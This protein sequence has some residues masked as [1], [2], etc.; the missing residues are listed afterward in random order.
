MSQVFDTAGLIASIDR[1]S[2][3]LKANAAELVRQAAAGL[4]AD[5][6]AKMPRGT[7]PHRPGQ[8]PR[9]LADRVTAIEASDLIHIVYSNAPHLHLVE[10][11][12][13]ARANVTRNGK[14]L[15]TPAYRG[16]MPR[17]G[18]IF[19]PLAESHRARMLRMAE[20]LIGLDVEL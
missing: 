5:H 9:H 3:R 1:A 11:G 17:M 13:R 16:E 12:T 14:T 6:K 10:L 4:V 18:P 19:V 15:R 7:K 8:D 20:A 2:A